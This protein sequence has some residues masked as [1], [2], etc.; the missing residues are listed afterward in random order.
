MQHRH[1]PDGPRLERTTPPLPSPVLFPEY[2]N[3]FIFQRIVQRLHVHL[4]PRD[5]PSTVP[6]T[7]VTRASMQ[8]MC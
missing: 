4:V 8:G 3:D 2:N 1:T 7:L 5:A 6:R